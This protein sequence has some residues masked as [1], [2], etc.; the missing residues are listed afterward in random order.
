[1]HNITVLKPKSSD[2]PGILS[3]VNSDAEHLIQRTKAEIR[4]KLTFWRIV[5]VER[6]VVACGCFDRYS[7]RMAEVR[8]FIVHP[9]H[10]GNGYAKAILKDLLTL[11]QPGQRVFVVTSL[12]DFFKKN[13]FS[14]CLQE[15]YILFYH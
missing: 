1:M 3:L 9:E 11:S 2:I 8:S 5:K 6:Q 7:K 4:K 14:E 13:A 15:K 12:P 10:R